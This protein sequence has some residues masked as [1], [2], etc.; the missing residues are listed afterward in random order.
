[1][2]RPRLLLLEP[3]A[4]PASS[5]SSANV[6]ITHECSGDESESESCARSAG[7]GSCTVTWRSSTGAARGWAGCARRKD[8]RGWVERRGPDAEWVRGEVPLRWTACARRRGSSVSV[9]LRRREAEADAE[10]KDGDADGGRGGSG[11]EGEGSEEVDTEVETG[12][13][14]R[15]GE[16]RGCGCAGEGEEDPDAEPAAGLCCP[17]FGD[18]AGEELSWSGLLAKEYCWPRTTVAAKPSLYAEMASS[19][20]SES[21]SEKASASATVDRRLG[22]PG[23]DSRRPARRDSVLPERAS[24]C[25]CP[26]IELNW[27]GA[28]T[29]GSAAGSRFWFSSST[30]VL[31]APLTTRYMTRSSEPCERISWLGWTTRKVKRLDTS[32]RTHV[33][34]PWKRSTCFRND[35]MSALSMSSHMRRLLSSE[36]ACASSVVVEREPDADTLRGA[37]AEEEG[38]ALPRRDTRPEAPGLASVTSSNASIVSR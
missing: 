20:F 14:G 27:A 35:T 28:A 18:G 24:A 17:A 21:C 9:L 37:D 11:M 2:P 16:A 19:T 13:A 29:A 6:A 4:M 31:T 12:R 8:A 36:R 34:R 25:R 33:S 10:E 1:M 5:S 22:S 15:S 32:C 3:F 38:R 23:H 26:R 7:R 30:K